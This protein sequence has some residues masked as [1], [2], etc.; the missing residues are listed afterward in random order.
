VPAYTD[1]TIKN[2]VSFGC[3]NKT[4]VQVVQG[5][6]NP[7]PVRW[8]GPAVPLVANG[9]CDAKT[10]EAIKGVQRRYFSFDDGKID[11]K[12][13]PTL[14]V[15]NEMNRAL[16]EKGRP[17][18]AEFGGDV[19]GHLDEQKQEAQ[20]LC[21]AT[22]MAILQTWWYGERWLPWEAASWAGDEYEAKFQHKEGL[23]ANVGNVR[24]FIEAL[25]YRGLD[26]EVPLTAAGWR[27][28]LATQPVAVMLRKS[29]GYH[30]RVAYGIK[31]DGTLH[32]TSV[33]ICDPDGGR[34][35]WES[36]HK[37]ARLYQASDG[38]AGVRVWG[39]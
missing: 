20:M 4:D 5:L 39:A 13:S 18:N 12:D 23:D 2:A 22:A 15:L 31:T 24:G 8:G 16:A 14:K 32:G 3:W 21:W 1:K 34:T 10:V 33:H 35:Y 27:A 9:A 6:L 29:W 17:G 25:G 38:M 37:F 28:V 26:A 36:F 7:I 19:P 11:A 30:V